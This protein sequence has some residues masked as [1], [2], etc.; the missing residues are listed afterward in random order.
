VSRRQIRD[1]PRATNAPTKFEDNRENKLRSFIFTYISRTLVGALL[2]A[3]LFA[4]SPPVAAASVTQ[5]RTT[6]DPLA[7][8]GDIRWFNLTESRDQVW[9]NFGPPKSVEPFGDFESWQY[10]ID[11]QDNHDFSHLLVFR[12]STGELVSV[13]RNYEPEKLV[14]DLFAEGAVVVHAFPD[15]PH[16]KVRVRKLSGGRVLLAMGSSGPGKPVEQI[17]LIRESELANFQ[18]WIKLK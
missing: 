8:D 7:K 6:T 14:D 2:G 5:V 11:S 9:T 10:Q 17:I 12:K 15:D 18:P 4:Q 1:T 13:T 3:P 16:F